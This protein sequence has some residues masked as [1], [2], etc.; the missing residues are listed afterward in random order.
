MIFIGVWR[1]HE[2]MHRRRISLSDIVQMPE[3][4]ELLIGNYKGA[5]S[6][7][8]TQSPEG[9]EVVLLRVEDEF[10]LG[11]VNEINFQ[12][13]TIPVIVRGSFRRPRALSRRRVA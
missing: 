1:T 5:Y 3:V 10:P 6:V 13:E 12:G 11:F 8:I 2:I 9:E 4:H 7:G